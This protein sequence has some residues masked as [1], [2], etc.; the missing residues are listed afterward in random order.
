MREA[1]PSDQ[2]LLLIYPL[3]PQYLQINY[4]KPVIALALSLPITS[5]DGAEWVINRKVANV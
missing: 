3:D 2:G 1:R 4:D 5:D